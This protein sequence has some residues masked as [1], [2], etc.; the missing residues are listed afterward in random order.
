MR[1]L[2]FS[3]CFPSAADPGSGLFVQRR[4]EALADVARIN[5][6]H[7]VGVCPV[8]RPPTGG[9]ELPSSGR[10]GPLEVH[11]L[12]FGYLPGLLKR[13]HP[14]AYARGVA[15]W[16]RRHVRRE[17]CDLLDA[18]FVWP[19]GVAVSLLARDLNLPYIITL[20]GT[21]IPRYRA[22]AYRPHIARALGGAAA[23]ISVTQQMADIAVSLGVP[24]R[25]VS[26]VPNGVDAGE[27][28]IIDRMAARR[29]LKLGDEGP[30]LVCVASLK[31][32]KGQLDLLRALAELGSCARLVLVGQP[33][34]RGFERRLRGAAGE[35]CLRGRVQFAGRQ[36]PQRVGLY[37]NAADVVVL[38]SWNEGCPNVVLEAMACGAPVVATRVGGV[39]DI[40]DPAGG[41]L[42]E[43]RRPQSLAAA[44]RSALQTSWD[45]TAI[46]RC[47]TARS[48]QTVAAE[49]A[50][51]WRQ[52][53]MAQ[54]PAESIR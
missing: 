6:V 10:A 42:C 30:L 15:D 48:W 4:L 31:P 14:W 22:R 16:V 11:H 35:G 47:A 44:L 2:S 49:V 27:F 25:R 45:R 12:P 52:A 29:E 54:A 17:G 5:V 28:T 37:L 32:A 39:P 21:I 41:V 24:A 13:R 18:H 50:P 46:R 38:P 9:L 43:P 53:A 40:L 26:V 23:V 36:P 33:A 1:V 7:P 34:A 3:S 8:L 20:R 51:V 19:D